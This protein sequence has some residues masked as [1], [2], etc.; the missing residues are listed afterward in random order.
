MRYAIS[1]WHPSAPAMAARFDML[2]NVE[3]W[4]PG[5]TKGATDFSREAAE[6]MKTHLIHSGYSREWLVVAPL[7]EA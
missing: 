3:A 4:L 1:L 2:G 7:P 6:H 5:T